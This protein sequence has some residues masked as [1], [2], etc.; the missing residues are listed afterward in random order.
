MKFY[1]SLVEKKNTIFDSK[2]KDADRNHSYVPD[3]KLLQKIKG[4]INQH[5]K[6]QDTFH[7]KSNQF[8]SFSKPYS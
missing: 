2:T 4:L 1:N 6:A 8:K 7:E 5:D 3:I